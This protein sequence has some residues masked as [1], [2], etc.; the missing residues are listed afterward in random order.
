[1]QV[2]VTRCKTTWLEYLRGLPPSHVHH[3]IE[4]DIFAFGD[5]IKLADELAQLVLA[6]KKTATASLAVEFRSLN[7][8]LPGVGGVCII[9]CGDGNP[10]AIIERTDVKTVPFQ[11]VDEAFAELEGEGDRSL[12]YWR[13]A[14]AQYFTRVC[15]RLGGAFAATTP[16]LC[17]TFRLLWRTKP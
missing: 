6:G 8:P 15:N 13:E 1:M 9:V 7:E 17:Q 11:S 12:A 4:P 10:V 16:V 5:S 14:H 2:N 3:R